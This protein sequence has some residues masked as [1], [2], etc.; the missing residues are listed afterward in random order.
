LTRPYPCFLIGPFS[1]LLFSSLVLF[2]SLVFLR[3]TG[4]QHSTFL[5]SPPLRG[6]FSN[7][8]HHPNEKI[9][10]IPPP[11]FLFRIAISTRPPW[12]PLPGFFP[13]CHT[14][15]PQFFFFTNSR[16]APL[17]PK[18]GRAPVPP[19]SFPPPCNLSNDFMTLTH[20]LIF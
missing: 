11:P 19:V 1:P 6:W 4:A 17:Q 2:P 10:Q 5:S 13:S 20:Q 8:F 16:P 18:L 7:T 3:R 15:V 12:R 14:Q 9:R